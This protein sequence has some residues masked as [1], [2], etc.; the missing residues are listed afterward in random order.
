MSLCFTI[1]HEFFLFNHKICAFL[2]VLSLIKTVVFGA[3]A[4]TESSVYMECVGLRN[5]QVSGWTELKWPCPEP[6]QEFYVRHAAFMLPPIF[7][8]HMAH[9][10]LLCVLREKLLLPAGFPLH[11][12]NALLMD[13]KQ[14]RLFTLFKLLLHH[15][16]LCWQSFKIKTKLVFL[17]MLL[18]NI[19]PLFLMMEHCWVVSTFRYKGLLCRWIYKGKIHKV[20]LLC[21]K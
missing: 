12:G 1:Q 17:K 8:Q 3:G 4:Q 6:S 19:K 18:V 11:W 5:M 13:Y 20:T 2:L 9:P 7:K 21:V 15:W 16:K 14:K 10:C